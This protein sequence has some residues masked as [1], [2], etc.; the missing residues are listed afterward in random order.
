[1]GVREHPRERRARK[2][3][4]ENARTVDG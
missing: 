1:M 2:G 3:N 4:E